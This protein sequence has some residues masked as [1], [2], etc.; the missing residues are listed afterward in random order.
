M[1][2]PSAGFDLVRR[3]AEVGRGGRLEGGQGTGEERSQGTA[4][5]GNSPVGQAEDEELQEGRLQQQVLVA[6]GQLSEA[7]DLLSPLAD[8]LQGTR[9]QVVELLHVPG[10]FLPKV[11]QHQLL[12]L[13]VGRGGQ[14]PA[15][16][17]AA[18]PPQEA[19]SCTQR[20]SRC[21]GGERGPEVLPLLL[22]ANP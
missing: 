1:S 8:H 21:R 13:R 17:P 15:K 12:E 11:G 14:H 9:K 18:G 16:G 2:F 4:D 7:R 6:W 22:L 20:I 19:T 10:I 3:N 5:S